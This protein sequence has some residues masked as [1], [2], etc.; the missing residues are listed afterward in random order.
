M[1]DRDTAIAMSVRDDTPF[2]TL[3]SKAVDQPGYDKAE[4]LALEKLLES[5]RPAA[6]EQRAAAEPGSLT[7]EE[8][9]VA[10][11]KEHGTGVNEYTFGFD[12]YQFKEW[13]ADAIRAA[14]AEERE[15][16]AKV[17]E[18]E[19]GQWENGHDPDNGPGTAAE[20]IA[21]AIRERTG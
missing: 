19:K 7:P 17:A 8:R 13:F 16:C 5:R 3:W 21:K 4:W 9:V 1:P 14:V 6:P 10:F 20:M 11:I 15:A 18:A 2:H 12:A